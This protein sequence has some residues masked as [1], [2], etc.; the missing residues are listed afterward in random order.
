M[1]GLLEVMKKLRKQQHG[2][3]RWRRR[4]FKLE[5]TGT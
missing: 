3:R 1:I 5:V 2:K 4:I